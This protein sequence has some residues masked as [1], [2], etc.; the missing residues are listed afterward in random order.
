V[1]SLA[2][3]LAYT[4]PVRAAIF[5]AYL[6]TGAVAGAAA[7]DYDVLIVGGQVLDGSGT[8][9]YRADVALAAGRIA[10]VGDLGRAKAA[11]VIRA[12]GLTIVPGMIDLHSHADGSGE[13]G[14]LRSP[15][16]NRRAAPNLVAQ[17]VTTVVVNQDGRSLVDLKRQRAQLEAQ[18]FGPNAILM[19][20]HNTLRR[21]A[22]ADPR[23]RDATADEIAAMKAMLRE[24]MEAGA[25]GLTAGL[26][27]E[28]GIWSTTEEL[29]ELVREVKPYHGLYIVHE[30]ASGIDP[31]WFVP[32]RDDHGGT[33]PTMLDSILETIQIA[34]ATGVTSVAT[35]IKARGR[36]YWGKS[37]EIIGAIQ[38]ARDRGVPIYADAYPYDTSGSDGTMVLIPQWVVDE[39]GGGPSNYAV[40]LEAALADDDSAK[41]LARDVMHE[42]VQRGGPGNIVVLDHPD[43]SLIGE[44]LGE[45]AAT[46]T[47]AVVEMAYLLQIEG[48]RDRFGGATLRGFS[49]NEDD[50][51]NFAKQ[52]WVATASDAGIALP[53]EPFTHSRY[54]GTFPRKIRKYALDE[55]LISVEQAVRSMTGLPADILEL[56]DRGY[57]RGGYVADLAVIDLAAVRDLSTFFAP[58]QYPAGI[59]FVM[60]NG[61]FVVD[62]GELTWALPGRV[63]TRE[64]DRARADTDD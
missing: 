45:M 38:S 24:G 3:F 5:A 63:L 53:G 61:V 58:H 36:A 31:M 40:A 55:K 26:E 19:V 20:G 13:N 62:G 14:G 25:W 8:A 52:P 60:V 37:G 39:F 2:R 21:T 44:T 50:V 64:K 16:A 29:V 11:R 59:P 18:G 22:L 4:R 6:L 34:E 43:R 10:A 7:Q 35:H 48:Y 57:V 49:L 12:E 46:R 1:K 30:R 15:D 47:V 54:Y 41:A 9:A 42:I 51:R 56:H 23:N 33:P 28:P 27:Y 17:G 32:S